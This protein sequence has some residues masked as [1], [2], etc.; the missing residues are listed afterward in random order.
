MRQAVIVIPSLP[1]SGP[2]KRTHAA[3]DRRNVCGA[4]PSGDAKDAPGLRQTTLVGAP[5]TARSVPPARSEPLPHFA[6][7]DGLAWPR[8]WKRLT[9]HWISTSRLS[10]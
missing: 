9:L 7:Q 3:L 10:G 4:E 2:Y 1:T 6:R 8:L 5:R